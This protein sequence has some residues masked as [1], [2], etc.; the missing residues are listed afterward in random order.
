[1]LRTASGAGAHRWRAAALFEKLCLRGI[2]VINTGFGI[3]SEANMH[4]PNERFPEAHLERG[5][6]AVREILTRLG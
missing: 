6:A 5:V 4:G 1:M 2:A 3:E